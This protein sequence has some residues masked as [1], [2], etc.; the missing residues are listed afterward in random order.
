MDSITKDLIEAN[1]SEFSALWAQRFRQHRCAE[2]FI[3]RDFPGDY[4][5]N[6]TKILS[7]CSDT[8]LVI[9]ESKR[10]FFANKLDCFIHCHD[11]DAFGDTYIAL[12]DANFSFKDSMLIFSTG[13]DKQVVTKYRLTYDTS[14]FRIVAVDQSLVPV[15]VDVFCKA[16]DAEDW[17]QRINV[18]TMTNYRHFNLFLLMTRSDSVFVPAACALLFCNN[19]VTGL[20]CLG[21]LPKFRRKGLASIILKSSI[22]MARADRKKLFFAQTFASGGLSEIYNKAGLDLIY[23]K[24]V[25]AL[26]RD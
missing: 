26:H 13:Q 9:A 10:I 11:S 6:K 25:Y 23:K 4:F 22:L 16:F 24:R 21:T 14:H 7:P 2:L 1:D 3:N 12:E 15:W 20:Y 17:K 19:N 18:L 5:F 8:S